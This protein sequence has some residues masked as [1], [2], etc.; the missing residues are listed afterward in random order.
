MPRTR[1]ELCQLGDHNYLSIMSRRIFRAGLKHSMVDGKW[2]AFEEVFHGFDIDRVRM[3]SDDDLEGFM[4][5]KRIIRH[6]GKIKAVRANAQAIYE[7]SHEA[8]G[9]GGYLAD[10]S[11]E[12]IVRLWD[13]LKK[14]FTQLGGHSGPYF[15]RMVGKDTFLLTKFVIRALQKWGVIKDEPKGKKANLE[16]QTIFNHWSEECGRPLCQLSMILAL[17]VD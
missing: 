5:E 16:M 1:D 7:L 8:Q 14:R 15:L 17:S 12:Q 13:D 2:P 3:L 4:K 6:W 11:G 9:I 10:W